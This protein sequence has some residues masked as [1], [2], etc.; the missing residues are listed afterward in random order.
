MNNYGKRKKEGDAGEKEKENNE[1]L[2]KNVQ[3]MND[4]EGGIILLIFISHFRTYL[5]NK[6]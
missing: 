2:N 3:S 5:S 4:E 6:T 1:M